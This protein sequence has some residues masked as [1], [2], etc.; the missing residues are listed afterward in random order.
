MGLVRYLAAFLPK[1]A[2]FTV[3]LDELTRKECEKHFPGWKPRHQTAFEE[4]KKLVTSTDCLTTI[5][6]RL[7]QTHKIFVTTDASDT[8][9]GAVLSFGPT[10]DTARP[11]AYDSHSF[12]G[13]ELNYPIHEKELLAIIRALQ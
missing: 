6:P 3:I 10:Y 5:D 8:G 4:I 1:L 13:A 11:V 2:K 9:S 12:K 7:M